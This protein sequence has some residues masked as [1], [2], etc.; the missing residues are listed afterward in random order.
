M[1]RPSPVPD[2]PV[3]WRRVEPDE[4]VEHPFAVGLGD[5]GPV[6]GDDHPNA[7][8]C[9]SRVHANLGS[10]GAMRDR[11]VEQGDEHLLEQLRVAFGLEALPPGS[12]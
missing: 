11:V 5:P 2:V 1:Y 7:R 6:V 12:P 4:A 9:P 8:A 10:G 3:I